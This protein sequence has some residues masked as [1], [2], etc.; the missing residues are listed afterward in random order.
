MARLV[1]TSPRIFV[2]YMPLF[3]FVETSPWGSACTPEAAPCI[4]G[5]ARLTTLVRERLAAEP[6]SLLLNGG[7]SFQGTIWYNILKWN[8]TQYFMNLLPHDAHV[9]VVLDL[10]YKYLF[11]F[12]SMITGLKYLLHL[13]CCVQFRYFLAYNLSFKN[14][15]F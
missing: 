4:G 6:H 13:E 11:T 8:V 14:L 3:R 1:A 9:S 10:I 12:L 7:D 2:F 15:N 5:F